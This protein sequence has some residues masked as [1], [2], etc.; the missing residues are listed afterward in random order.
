MDAANANDH[1][2]TDIDERYRQSLDAWDEGVAEQ[3]DRQR[4]D[5]HLYRVSLAVNAIEVALLALLLWRL[6]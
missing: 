2:P 3:R 6:W 1:L 5:S 4:F